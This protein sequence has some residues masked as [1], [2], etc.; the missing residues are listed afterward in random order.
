MMLL[1]LLLALQCCTLQRPFEARNQCAL[2]MKIIES[3][4]QPPSN[5]AVSQEVINLVLWL[6]QKDPKHRPSTRHILNEA[7]VRDRL[8]ECNLEVPGDIMEDVVANFL[9]DKERNFKRAFVPPHFESSPRSSR[10]EAAVAYPKLGAPP[11]GGNSGGA[12]VA[13]SSSRLL[14]KTAHP[15]PMAADDRPAAARIRGD[16]VRGASKRIPSERA[17]NRYQ[18]RQA[19]A[20]QSASQEAACDHDDY[21]AAD[22]KVGSTPTADLRSKSSRSSKPWAE[23]DVKAHGDTR[24]TLQEEVEDSETV[25]SHYDDDFEAPDDADELIG[26]N[27]IA[28]SMERSS[29][30][31]L[32]C[33]A[34]STGD[35]SQQL[36]AA[37]AAA[38][39]GDDDSEL[40]SSVWTEKRGVI[41]QRAHLGA[42]PT[43]PAAEESDGDGAAASE[44]ESKA[45]ELGVK[46]RPTVS[47]PAIHF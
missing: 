9:A 18:M 47:S 27:G 23:S 12:K 37:A 40:W 30:R 42:A 16:R 10:E 17:L 39:A 13:A 14:P 1:P 29:E 20:A 35:L 15:H 6:L 41:G 32:P 24:R 34:H 25:S 43:S 45:A 36:L 44:E 3:P 7:F 38:A 33:S 22:G 21:L 4:V 8:A 26:A 11:S 31:L 5:S 19:G 46:V 2:I 28:G